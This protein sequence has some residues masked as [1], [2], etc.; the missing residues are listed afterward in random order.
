MARMPRRKLISIATA[1]VASLVVLL[2]I[3]IGLGYLVLP[4]ASPATVTVSKVEWH[5]LQGT[6]ST[7]MGWFGNSSF[8][9]TKSNGFPLKVQ[10][11]H[12]FGLPWTTSNFDSS[13]HSV[14]SVELNTPFKLDGSR[15]A[16]P[17]NATAGEDDVVF[18][19]TIG[20]PSSATGPIV[21]DIT[22]NA[23]VA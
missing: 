8:N 7:G 15:P 3:L 21:L 12:S 5:V 9:Y 2:L 20:V 13:A 6:T 1:A 16:L 19:F 23:L 22:I 17:V 14:Y 4:S 18:E 10:A 11:G